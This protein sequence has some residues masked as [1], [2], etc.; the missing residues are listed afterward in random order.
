MTGWPRIFT[1]LTIAAFFILAFLGLVLAHTL[2]YDPHATRDDQCEPW[3][4]TQIP[5]PWCLNI[6]IPGQTGDT[7]SS[8]S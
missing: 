7:W 6:R 2:E 5:R 8:G 1:V 3:Q 4:L